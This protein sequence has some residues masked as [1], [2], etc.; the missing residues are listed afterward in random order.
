MEPCWNVEFKFFYTCKRKTVKIWFVHQRT[1]RVNSSAAQRHSSLRSAAFQA[2][3]TRGRDLSRRSDRAA[4]WDRAHLATSSRQLQLWPL[5]PVGEPLLPFQ[6]C[7]NKNLVDKTLSSKI[8]E[9]CK[10]QMFFLGRIVQ[11]CVTAEGQLPDSLETRASQSCQQRIVLVLF[12]PYTTHTLLVQT[13]P[14]VNCAGV[15]NPQ[16]TTA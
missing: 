16:A 5:W 9:K 6:V 11:L 1:E 3:T 14:R 4:S 2:A 10:S 8:D 13:R 7:L 15:C 12:F